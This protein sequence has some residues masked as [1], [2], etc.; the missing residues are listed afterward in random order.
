MYLSQIDEWI[1]LA[2]KEDIGSGDVTTQSIISPTSISSGKLIAKEQ[3]IVCGLAVVKRIF[4]LID[5]RIQLDCLVGDGDSVNQG[6]ILALVKGPSQGILAGERTALNILQRLSGVSTKTRQAVQEIEGTN[7][8]IVDTRKTTPGMRILEKY[9]VKTGG[10][11]NHRT[12]LYDGILIKD[13]HIQAAGSITAAIHN[14]RRHTHH[15]LKIEIEV[16]NFAQ[17]KEALEANADI[18]M[19]DNMS[20]ADMAEAVRIVNG[21]ALTEASGNMGEYNLKKVAETGVNLISIGSLTH[22]AR[23]MDISLRF[24]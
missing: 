2:L 20:V 13:N 18:I 11:T 23:A 12:G 15:L 3:L 16:E 17:L 5:S 9:A 19:L 22:S 6:D 8:V 24:D 4:E 1:Y 14:A 7:A 21:R 10:G